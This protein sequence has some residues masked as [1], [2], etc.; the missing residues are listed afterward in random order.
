MSNPRLAKLRKQPDSTW[1]LLQKRLISLPDPFQTLFPDDVWSFIQKKADSLSTNAGYVATCL[2]TT[3]SFVGGLG[4]T[5]TNGSQEMPLN[6]YSIF[7]GP[8]TTGKSQ[9]LKECAAS[10]MS[11][12]AREQ[13]SSSY[14]INN[15][16][17]SG[18]IKAIAQN[19][20]GYLLSAEIYDVLFKLL[21]SDEEN[22]TG[23]VQVLCQLFSGEGTSFRY[24]TERTREIAENTTFSILGSTQVPFAARLITVLDQGHGLL[25]R[26]L[27]TFPKCL[28]PTPTQ[29]DQA[30]EYL[31]NLPLSSCDDIFIEIAR[32]HSKRTTYSLSDDARHLVNLI[33][34]EFIAEVNAAIS[35]GRSPPKTKKVDIVLRVAVSLHIFNAVANKLIKGEE[36]TIPEQQIDKSAVE[37]A[38]SYVSWAESQK[39]IFVEVRYYYMVILICCIRIIYKNQT[40]RIFLVFVSNA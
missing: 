36:P 31:S 38:I 2:L 1:A 5:L 10:P 30:M 7:V 6:L 40:N 18:L 15:C 25:D 32:L 24:A 37:N 8:P 29:T 39:E 4:A 28:R 3:T 34:E 16:T 14:I 19:E 13:D 26:F 27:I 9:A 33:N 23:D 22:A 12:V 17:S 35:E 11:A 20:N 21:K